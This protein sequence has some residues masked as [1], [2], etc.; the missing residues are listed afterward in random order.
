[1]VSGA[2]DIRALRQ[3][4]R[5]GGVLQAGNFFFEAL[6]A[7]FQGRS[8]ESVTLAR[9]LLSFSLDAHFN[10]EHTE[11]FMRVSLLAAAFALVCLSAPST[12]FGP[13]EWNLH[14][15]E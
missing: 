15:S 3:I 6:S 13:S 7:R 11:E 14:R 9:L 1:M 5:G 12:T 2:A 10:P 8:P 4:A